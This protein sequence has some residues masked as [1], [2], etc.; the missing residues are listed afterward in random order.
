VGALGSTVVEHLARAGIGQIT[1]IDRDHVE[2][3]NLVRHAA[4]LGMAGWSKAAA[5]SQIAMNVGPGIKADVMNRSIGAPRTDRRPGERNEIGIW[6][7]VI[8]QVDLVLDCTA[9]KGLQQALAWLARRGG[10]P[11]VAASATNGGWG[12]R[13]VRLRPTPGTAC[14]S[15]LEYSI[16]DESIPML[17]AAPETA[18]IQPVGCAEP[19]FAGSGFDLAEVALH[20]VR[21]A[22][23]TVQAGKPGG[24]PDIG[25]DVHVLTLRTSDGV[26][27]A[28]TWAGL[29]LPVHA[30]CTAE[31]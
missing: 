11:Y 23:A 13:V 3:G 14:W 30:S 12:G 19:T 29:P 9:E 25:Q 22:V 1:T 17:S 24:Y 10:K 5:G 21:V 6:T 4:N 15:C 18:G 31:H 28:P 26:P 16:N 20:A 8:D 27:I 2:P 7:E